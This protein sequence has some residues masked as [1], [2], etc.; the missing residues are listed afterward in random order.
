MSEMSDIALSASD[1]EVSVITPLYNGEQWL[2]DYFQSVIN[3]TYKQPFEISIYNDGST[4]S[5]MSIVQKWIPFLAKRHIHVIIH[6]HSESPKGVGL[7]KNKAVMQSRG[8][9]LCFLDADDIMHPD[10]IAKQLELAK[11]CPNNTIVGCQFHRLPEGSTERYTK[12]ANTLTES[13]LKTQ[14]FTSHGPTVIMP[15]WFCH[16]SVF[17]AIQS[18]FNES[19]KGTPEDLIFFLEHLR[20]GGHVTRVNE[21]LLMYRYHP[22]AATFSVHE[23]TIWDIRL[24]A[25]QERVLK[26]WSRFTIWN[27]G[28]QGRKLYRCLSDANKAKVCAFCDVD[29]KKLVKG[30]YVYEESAQRP[31]PKVPI[32][33]FSV[34]Q[35]PFIICVKQDLTGGVF[36]E[37]LKSLNL[38]EGQD[39]YHFN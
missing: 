23:D 32:V 29:E 36:E 1:I 27:A 8:T 20:L 31:K 21:D 6:D 26:N 30:V 18:G 7:A 19:G 16:R 38:V 25:L 2:D 14:A 9:Y 22:N 39:Y 10:R 17:S 12:W 3:Q 13:Q 24:A 37:N 5:S 15:T 33:H 4:D 28:K 11:R 34:A 35:K